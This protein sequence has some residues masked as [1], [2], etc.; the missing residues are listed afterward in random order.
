M[1]KKCLLLLWK[2]ERRKNDCY[3]VFGDKSDVFLFF[4]DD[5]YLTR[6]AFTQEAHALLKERQNNRRV[7]E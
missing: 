3:L 1:R 2:S 6:L 7:T 4:K 5:K